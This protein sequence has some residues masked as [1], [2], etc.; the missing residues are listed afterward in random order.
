MSILVILPLCS[1]EK[2]SRV[3]SSDCTFIM[4]RPMISVAAPRGAGEGAGSGALAVPLVPA[5]FSFSL[6]I[7]AKGAGEEVG[8]GVAGLGCVGTA[9]GLD[10]VAEGARWG[11]EGGIAAAGGPLASGAGDGELVAGK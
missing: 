7:E 4:K 9:A 6:G 8:F 5:G 1:S 3:C 11:P 2:M 10:C